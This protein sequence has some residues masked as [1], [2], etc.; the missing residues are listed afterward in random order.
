MQ[1]REIFLCYLEL[2]YRLFLTSTHDSDTATR[3][4]KACICNKNLFNGFKSA[5]NSSWLRA[6]LK[7]TTIGNMPKRRDDAIRI[8]TLNTL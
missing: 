3:L 4:Q 5:R 8:I 1:N 7:G 2:Q 6:I